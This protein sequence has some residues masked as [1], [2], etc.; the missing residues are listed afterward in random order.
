MTSELATQ[1]STSV[2]RTASVVPGK[3]VGQESQNDKGLQGN[4]T[5]NNIQTD[6]N[7]E[8]SA[9]ANNVLHNKD[10]VQNKTQ[11]ISQADISEV[12]ERLNEF[13]KSIGRDLNFSVDKDIDR[14]VITVTDT[15]TDEVVRKIPTEE[16]L[17]VA[18]D[19]EANMSL[20]FNE[21]A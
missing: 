7:Q 4:S 21:E 20:L 8:V 14:V 11:D 2:V 15:Q 16:A 1:H 13:V 6:Q 10:A 3:A 17:A 19:I 5:N 18:K 9:Q 12:A